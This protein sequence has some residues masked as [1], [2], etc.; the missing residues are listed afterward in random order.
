MWNG[1]DDLDAIDLLQLADLLDREIGFAADE[2][3]GGEALRNDHRPGIDGG[4]NAEPLD[5]FCKQNAAGAEP[6]I[7]HRARAEQRRT[8]RSL[9]RDIGMGLPRLHGDA[10]KGSREIHATFRRHPPFA[11]DLVQ[12]LAGQDDDVG[13]LTGA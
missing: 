8:Q 11:G 2:P 13:R 3:L 12:P 6:R 7:G 1:T 9:G 4:G 5:Q 10:D